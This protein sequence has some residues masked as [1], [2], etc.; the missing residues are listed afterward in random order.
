M[1]MVFLGMV[2]VFW[3]SVTQRRGEIGLRRA[4]GARRTAIYGQ[5]LLEI[6]IITLF[7]CAVAAVLVVQLPLL[8]LVG[9]LGWGTVASALVLSTLLMCGLAAGSGLYPAWLAARIEPAHALHDE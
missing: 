4:M 3:Q 9:S 2:G 8:G 6:V 5:S 7:G 1:L